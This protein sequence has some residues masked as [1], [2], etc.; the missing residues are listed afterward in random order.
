MMTRTV[1]CAV[2]R[3]Q[4]NSGPIQGLHY[5]LHAPDIQIGH[6]QYLNIMD[7]R[8]MHLRLMFGLLTRIIQKGLQT[9][10]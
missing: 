4:V 3:C 7:I 2:S 1:D 6:R 10:E 5:H 8:L 9:V